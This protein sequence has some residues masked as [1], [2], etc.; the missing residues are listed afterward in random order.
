MIFFSITSAVSEALNTK[1]SEE[2]YKIAK[3]IK[4]TLSCPF[5]AVLL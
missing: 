2:V 5:L 3:N 4:A 1:I